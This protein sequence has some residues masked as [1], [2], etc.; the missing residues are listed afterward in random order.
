MPGN[1]VWFSVRQ[2]A[3]KTGLSL[4][5]VRYYER[6]GLVPPVGRDSAGRRRYTAEDVEWAVEWDVD[7][8]GP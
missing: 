1:S 6:I 5:T 7:P 3:E 2:A 4:D 8:G